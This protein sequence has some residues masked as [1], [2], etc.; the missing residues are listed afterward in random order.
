MNYYQPRNFNLVTLLQL[1]RRFTSYYSMLFNKDVDIDLPATCCRIEAL[2]S[3]YSLRH[4]EN[5]VRAFFIESS[6]HP[7]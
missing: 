3:M 5:S 4:D 6:F 7:Y 2:R 1:P